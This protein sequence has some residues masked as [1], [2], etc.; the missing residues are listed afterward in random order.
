MPM[1][2]RPPENVDTRLKGRQTTIP[3]WLLSGSRVPSGKADPWKRPEGPPIE[4]VE[5]FYE[6]LFAW[7]K[8]SMYLVDWLSEEQRRAD[9]A[10]FWEG[11]P[12]Y[13]SRTADV[14]D[15]KPAPLQ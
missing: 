9:Q 6:Y 11:G 15:R 10:E 4:G 2:V 3:D 1:R 7:R 13:V 8:L 5:K 14:A 12:E